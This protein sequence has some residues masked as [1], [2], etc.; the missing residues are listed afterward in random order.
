MRHHINRRRRAC[1][2]GI[3]IASIIAF[4]IGLHSPAYAQNLSV[5]LPGA[6][7]TSKAAI[8]LLAIFGGAMSFA[9]LSAFWLI[10]ERGRIGRENANL[11]SNFAAVRADRDRLLTM[12]DGGG[13]RIAIWDG[14]DHKA[15]MIGVLPAESGVPEDD[16]EFLAFGR[17][18]EPEAAIKLER[19]ISSL[20]EVGDQF[21]FELTTR[22]GTVIESEG[23]VLGGH[24]FVRFAFLQGLQEE[25]SRAQEDLAGVTAR[26][27]L[28]EALFENISSP[29]WL[30]SPAGNLLYVNKAYCEAVDATSRESVIE[31]TLELFDRSERKTI[32]AALAQSDQFKGQLPAICAGD[33]HML[34]TVTVR[35]Q[36]GQAG[37][38]VDRTDTEAVR[39]TLKH[40]IAG[41]QQT[42][43]RLAAGIAVFDASQRLL[44]HNSSFLQLFDL[45][46]G[47]L[48]DHPSNSDLLEQLRSSKK[49]PET[50]EWR[51]WKQT[52]LA[53]YHQTDA[54][55][56][57]W[58]LPD[59][60]TLR[61][62][63]NP[64]NQGGTSWVFENV[65]EELQLKTSYNALMR[66]QG[67]T[68]DHLSEAVA[69]FGSNGRIRLTNPAFL[70]F[71]GC[72]DQEEAG[73][74]HVNDL[75]EAMQ[76]R[77]VHKDEWDLIRLNIT[78]VSDDQRDLQGTLEYADGL[79]HDFRLVH[80]PGNQ[81]MLTLSDITDSVN[82]ERALKERNEA[83]EES[84]ALKTRFIQR[85]S[86]ELRAPLTTI[87]GFSEILASET[88][89]HLNE[90]QSE[91]LDY[92]SRS[93]D[94]LK[95]LIDDI[96]DLASID[97]GA[98]ELDLKEVQLCGIVTKGI[99]RLQDQL[100]RYQIKPLM[101]IDENATTLIGDQDRLQ[102]VIYNLLSNAASVSPDGG[103]I[104]VVAQREED[105]VIVR[106]N[107][108]GPGVDPSML[109]TIFE[110]FESG[111]SGG[112]SR[113]AGL[114]LSIVKS[115]V[116]L[117][118]GSVHIE[119]LPNRGASFVCTIPVD[120]TADLVAAE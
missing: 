95:S 28:L 36:N 56:D 85:V 99:E 40:T 52:L 64:Q 1:R 31:E 42:F 25:L 119:N 111:R 59:G 2:Y 110:R 117:H 109:N 8:L 105:K 57:Y 98:M 9:L 88:P 45:A 114:G 46:P 7:F 50:A 72:A 102:Q 22:A 18:L 84:D 86:Y 87:S 89:G 94:V 30:R 58:H 80:L 76:S 48:S 71:V 26:L 112:R 5:I 4:Q 47:D 120:P 96:L 116:E 19:A 24:A 91:Y 92:I 70:N 11:K 108:E 74:L 79:I 17:W 67:E 53:S 113:G 63:I 101:Q 15:R 54:L 27:G 49:L 16:R 90:K 29:V 83:L 12:V 100:D 23:K 55:E 82:V 33:R 61:V 65:T 39:A 81:T 35:A 107:D 13:Q 21:A 38:A 106:V 37:I 104:E 118:G 34:D 103:R 78:D 97:A 60:R 66:V 77:L 115:F 68:L 93:S 69:V 20:R 43:D 10:R 62:V 14:N 73:D 75:S 3:I 6:P 41:H 51:K 32:D 44:F